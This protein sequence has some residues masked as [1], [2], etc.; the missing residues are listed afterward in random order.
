MN[1]IH[2]ISTSVE[3]PLNL[4]RIAYDPG[5]FLSPFSTLFEK[6]SPFYG[7][8]KSSLLLYSRLD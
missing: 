2:R 3:I 5:S 8:S 1:Y 4:I 6:E 7:Y